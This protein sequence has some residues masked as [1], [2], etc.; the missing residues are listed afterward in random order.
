MVPRAKAHVVWDPVGPIKPLTPRRA[1][2][3]VLASCRHLHPLPAG[4]HTLATLLAGEG[5]AEDALP[6]PCQLTAT[7]LLLAGK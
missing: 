3:D 7:W 1:A 4:Q 6:G 2:S 5:W